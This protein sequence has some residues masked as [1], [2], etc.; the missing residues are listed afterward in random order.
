MVSGSFEQ[1]SK[2]CRDSIIHGR[3]KNNTEKLFRKMLVEL[4]IAMKLMKYV[5]FKVKEERSLKSPN[6]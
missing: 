6:E 3:S 1:A 5:T 2:P 4:S